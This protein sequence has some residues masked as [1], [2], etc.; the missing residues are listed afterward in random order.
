M[1][2]PANLRN[3][4]DEVIVLDRNGHYECRGYIVGRY[5]CDPPIYDV[6]PHRSESLSRRLCG[7]P[8]TRLRNVDKRVKAYEPKQEAQPQ[9]ILDSV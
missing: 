2:I 8:E 6:Q 4:G 1:T 9:R 7:I 5:A 3:H